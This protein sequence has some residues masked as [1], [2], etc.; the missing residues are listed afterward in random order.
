[1]I[2]SIKEK[3]QLIDYIE[4]QLSPKEKERKEKGEVFT[5]LSV[6]KEILD[7]L[8]KKLWKD[9]SLKWLDPATGIG[10]FP[11]MIYFRLMDGL[12]RWQPNEEKRRKHTSLNGK[13]T[14]AK[15]SSEEAVIFWRETLEKGLEGLLIDAKRVEDGGQSTLSLRKEEQ[16]S[17]EE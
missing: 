6:V 9:P 4:S 1:M 7:K 13:L 2:P 5:P 10:N 12:K 8:P 14:T 11:I 3:D 17:E 15:K 16:R